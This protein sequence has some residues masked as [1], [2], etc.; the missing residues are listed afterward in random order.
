MAHETPCCIVAKKGASSALRH[1]HSERPSTKTP[2]RLSSPGAPNMSVMMRLPHGPTELVPWG[3][4]VENG[5]F[6]WK[7][8]KTCGTCLV[9]RSAKMNCIHARFS[10]IYLNVYRLNHPLFRRWEEEWLGRW[11]T[12]VWQLGVGHRMH[13]WPKW[14]ARGGTAIWTREC[15]S[16]AAW[17]DYWLH[18]SM[19]P[20]VI[21]HGNG[22]SII[23]RSYS[24][25]IFHHIPIRTSIYRG[26]P[27]T[28]MFDDTCPAA[29]H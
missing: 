25:I 19:Y 21:N 9:S 4:F 12:H 1:N 10:R 27:K 29:D 20:P 26:F 7:T 11:W 23:C 13:K 18:P 6:L 2:R 28:N 15:V 22:K 24:I 5:W 14:D 8:Y 17:N 16:H 3:N